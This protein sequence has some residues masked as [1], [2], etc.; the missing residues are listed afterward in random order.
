MTSNLFDLS[1]KVVLITGATGH[2]GRA[3]SEGLAE[4][5][6][7]LAICST[8]IE[9]ARNLA[10]ELAE[11][12]SIPSEGFQLDLQDVDAIPGAVDGIVTRMGRLDCLVNNACFV[13]FNDIDQMTPAEWDEGLKGGVSSPFLLLQSCLKHLEKTRGCVINVGSM[14]G[15]VAPKP[16][17]YTD[18]PFS[19]A[20][21]YGAAKAALL[22]VTR[23][24]AAYLGSRG[25]RVNA[26]SP[27]PFPTE[28]VQQNELFKERLTSNVP[29]A[30]LGSPDE[31]KGAIVF[32]A[33]AASSYVTGHNLVVDGGWT[34]W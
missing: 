12:Y 22:Q 31:I 15:I 7:G 27:G 5:G 20:V 33:S 25:I 34:A 4:A 30:R 6:A 29:L 14:Y 18:T 2:L 3:M 10:A 23:Y 1:G 32:L 17:N 24:A 21:N 8:R 19:S 9:T 13:K 16:Q 28:Q 26:L 11:K